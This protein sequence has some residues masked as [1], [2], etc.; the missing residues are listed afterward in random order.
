MPYGL[1]AFQYIYLMRLKMGYRI[2]IKK[3]SKQNFFQIDL[4]RPPSVKPSDRFFLTP[5]GPRQDDPT[6]N[7]KV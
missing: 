6:K 5:D 4:F 7:R 3:M 2:E 1:N